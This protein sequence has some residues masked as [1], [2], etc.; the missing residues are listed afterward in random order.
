MLDA[1]AVCQL[2]RHSS[3]AAQA[4]QPGSGDWRKTCL[5]YIS[6]DEHLFLRFVWAGREGLCGQGVL[7]AKTSGGR[8]DVKHHVQQGIRLH[9]RR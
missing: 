9:V 5:D 4:Y 8:G 6:E 7:Q 2:H 3:T 1:C